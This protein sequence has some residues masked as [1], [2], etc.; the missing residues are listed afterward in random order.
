MFAYILKREVE[1]PWQ[2]LRQLVASCLASISILLH[3][4]NYTEMALL[5][6]AMHY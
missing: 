6:F 5:I 2:G 3:F 1:Y 4:Q